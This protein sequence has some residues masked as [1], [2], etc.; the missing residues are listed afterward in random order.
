MIAG[1]L[2]VPGLGTSSTN[3]QQSAQALKCP[4]PAKQQRQWIREGED[5][6]YT[7]RRMEFYGNQN[8]PDADIRRKILMNEGDFF[9]RKKLFA[10]ISSLNTIA[11]FRPVR[12]S[13]VDIRLDHKEKLVDLVICLKERSN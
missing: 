11:V 1:V 4:K 13:D 5:K 9:S 10:S 6:K 12:L 7:L 2:A 3:P 8:F